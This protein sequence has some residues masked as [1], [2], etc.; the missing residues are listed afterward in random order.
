MRPSY[1]NSEQRWKQ[2]NSW[3][4]PKEIC[5]ITGQ[6]FFN[7]FQVFEKFPLGTK[8]SNPV[9]LHSCVEVLGLQREE[10]LTNFQPAK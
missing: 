4:I 10:R 5:R 6:H 8:S 7:L 2:K 3:F 1:I 9:P